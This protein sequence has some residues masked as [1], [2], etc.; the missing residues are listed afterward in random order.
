MKRLSIKNIHF[1]I[2]EIEKAYKIMLDEHLQ[3]ERQFDDLMTYNS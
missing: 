2:K 3:T 1:H